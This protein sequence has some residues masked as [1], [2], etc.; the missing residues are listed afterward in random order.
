MSCARASIVLLLVSPLLGATLPGENSSGTA[1]GPA[2][3]REED[4][5]PAV[6]FSPEIASDEM[7]SHVTFLASDELR[8]RDTG[9]PGELAAANYLAQRL[10]AYGVL[11]GGDDGGYLRAVELERSTVEA[12]P[13]LIVTGADG[14]KEIGGYRTEFDA[15]FNV[16]ATGPLRVVAVDVREAEPMKP[17][18]G[19]AVVLVG[20]SGRSRRWL[21]ASGSSDGS[22]WGLVVRSGSRPKQQ[23]TVRLPSSLRKAPTGAPKESPSASWVR[24]YD[25]LFERL[26]GGAVTTV[27]LKTHVVVEVVR[28]ANVVGVLEGNGS[29]ERPELA[30]ET[31]VVSAHYDHIGL[32]GGH[33]GDEASAEAQD[34]I[35]NGADDNASGT[36]AVIEL[37]GA[38]AAGPPPART[39]VFL[40]ATGEEKGLLGTL[41]YLDDPTVP[42]ENTV[43]NLNIEMIGRPDPLVGGA[44][45]LWMVGWDLTDL[46]PALEER[47]LA[48]VADPRPEQHFFERSDNIAFVRRGIVGQSLS[49][50][51]MHTDY[52]KVS[53]EADTLDYEHLATCT[54]EALRALRPIVEGELTPAWVGDPPRRRR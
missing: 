33:D 37:A 29:D 25:P 32:H 35:Y 51:S 44:G 28:A 38:L 12:L 24:V 52:H 31:V 15:R 30:R 41:A 46:G 6:V 2:S 3:G 39:V 53:D 34:L 16:P 45:K 54:R 1:G 18:P 5:S 20:T 9:S 22:G 10:K 23:R 13:E 42:L 47:G 49:S 50:Y 43:F 14:S 36:A 27:E 8:G 11:P 26:A 17:D 7:R 4:P 48:I 40:L 21:E 19:V